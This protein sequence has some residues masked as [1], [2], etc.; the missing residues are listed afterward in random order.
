MIHAGDE[1]SI[2]TSLDFRSPNGTAHHLTIHSVKVSGKYECKLYSIN[3]D[4][5]DQITHHV[6]VNEGKIFNQ[7]LAPL[8]ISYCPVESHEETMSSPSS[9]LLNILSSL[10]F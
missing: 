4:I 2:S 7:L 3:G 10:F 1:H 9:S 8:L 5:Q 6:V